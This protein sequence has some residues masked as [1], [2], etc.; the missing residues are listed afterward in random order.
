M[1]VDPPFAEIPPLSSLPG[2]TP[3][4]GSSC[5]CKNKDI[6]NAGRF[7]ESVIKFFLISEKQCTG[8]ASI[9]QIAVFA[10]DCISADR[11]C[12][13]N[14]SN[15]TNQFVVLFH[16]ARIIFC[17]YYFTYKNLEP[18]IAIVILKLF[19]PLFSHDLKR[20]QGSKKLI[21]IDITHRPPAR[22]IQV[23]IRGI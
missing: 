11:S 23:D 7:C 10:L 16:L 20:I 15:H 6:L 21:F 3:K 19:D 4:L 22:S 5:L 1:V 12:F 8:Y 17:K 14:A 2:E 9:P 18:C 13:A